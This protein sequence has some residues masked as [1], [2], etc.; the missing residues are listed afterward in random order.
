M[1]LSLIVG[2]FKCYAGPSK[3][4]TICSF[5]SRS[6]S[7]QKSSSCWQAP[8]QMITEINSTRKGNKSRYASCRKH[9]THRGERA[10]GS[11]TIFT[12][13]AIFSILVV[14]RWFG[15]YWLF[16]CTNMGEINFRTV[17][18]QINK[19]ER[20][21]SIFSHQQLWFQLW[22]SCRN[23]GKSRHQKNVHQ[24][25]FPFFRIIQN[26]T[27]DLEYIRFSHDNQ[28]ANDTWLSNIEHFNVVYG[29]MESCFHV[30]WK[31]CCL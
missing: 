11:I 1:W 15:S 22:G 24:S 6:K 21:A 26:N 31:S 3:L 17:F 10:R 5:Y 13:R 27:S 9:S 4:C 2:W 25:E 8:E 16:Y 14:N 18:S 19:K 28:L 30:S 7:R 29:S 20:I 12:L 23:W